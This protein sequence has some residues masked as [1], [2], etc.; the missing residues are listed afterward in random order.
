MSERLTR[1]ASWW[2]S[3]D[4]G[5]ELTLP[6]AVDGS[7]GTGNASD[8]EVLCR[9]TEARRSLLIRTL[10]LAPQEAEKLAEKVAQKEASSK[11]GLRVKKGEKDV[12]A[13]PAPASVAENI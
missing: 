13:K 12:V 6:G 3:G 8:V 10:L 1:V 11:N 7:H 5:L 2:T 9:G 4:S